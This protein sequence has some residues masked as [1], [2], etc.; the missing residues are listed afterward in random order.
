VKDAQGYASGANA[1]AF[2]TL[3]DVYRTRQMSYD[4]VFR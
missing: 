3:Q 4:R 1:S 2:T